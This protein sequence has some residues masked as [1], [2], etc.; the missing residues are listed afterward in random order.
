[1][2]LRSVR[3]T[4]DLFGDDIEKYNIIQKEVT[5]MKSFITN[6]GQKCITKWW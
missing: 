3:G 5:K 1:M 6:K 2:K 4:H